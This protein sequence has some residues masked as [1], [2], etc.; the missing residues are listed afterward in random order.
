MGFTPYLTVLLLMKSTF[1][2]ALQSLLEMMQ[3]HDHTNLKM[4]TYLEAMY[5][6]IHDSSSFSQKIC[7]I[8]QV[9]WSQLFLAVSLLK[10]FSGAG[11]MKV[12]A[13]FGLEGML[14][15][16]LIMWACSRGSGY[17]S[18]G[19]KQILMLKDAMSLQGI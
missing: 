15:S 7:Q 19:K 1:S 9:L 14:S 8:S 10:M 2:G 5:C 4:I 6:K 3:S 16:V 12:G 17:P 13:S 11:F 18:L